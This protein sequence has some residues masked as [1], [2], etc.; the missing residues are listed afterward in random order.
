MTYGGLIKNYLFYLCLTIFISTTIQAGGFPITI[1]SCGRTVKINRPPERA[2]SS[3]LNTTEIMLALN[4]E[5]HLVGVGG[6]RGKDYQVL[7]VYKKGFSKVKRIAAN[8]PS[9]KDIQK[10]K[11]DFVFAGWNYGLKAGQLTPGQLD[12]VNIKTYEL[13]ESCIHVGQ[14][15]AKGI[16]NTF[17]DIRNIG[18]IFG[19]E[20]RAKSLI[21]EQM[22]QLQAIRIRLSPVKDR[23]SVFVYDSGVKRPFTS[24]RYGTPNTLIELAGGIHI[25]HDLEANWTEVDWQQ[26]APKKPQV[27][28]VVDYDLP[29]AQQKI[30]FLLEQSP[31][32]STPLSKERSFIILPYAAV[33]PGIRNIQSVKMI[34][35]SLYPELF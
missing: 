26:V 5:S 15:P 17:R 6:M 34:A 14:L 18:K 16:E 28:I 33:T 30:T 24:G 35:K 22:K 12:K 3:D 23:K 27:I 31:I 13:S 9:L 29:T 4:L 10:V 32:K 7:P 19:V 25:F 11:A 8:Y 20:H 1:K 2:I 21:S